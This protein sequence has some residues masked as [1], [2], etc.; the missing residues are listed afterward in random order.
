MPSFQDA[1]RPSFQPIK[2]DNPRADFYKMYER[3]ANEYDAEDIKKLNK[4][5]NTTSIVVRRSSSALV[6]YLT[7]SYRQVYSLSS[8]PLSSSMS[9]H[10]S[11]PI[12]TSNLWLSSVPSSSLST[13]P[14]SPVRSP[15]FHVSRR[16]HR[17]ESSPPTISCARVS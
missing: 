8:A 3:E 2:T 5:L 6:S 13:S 16:A 15:S 14:P 4:D 17:E 11:N 9:I 1:S 12:Q 10:S 7:C